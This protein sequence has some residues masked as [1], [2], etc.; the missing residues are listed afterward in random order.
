MPIGRD[1]R[2][3]FDELSYLERSIGRTGLLALKPVLSRN[4]RDLWEL[5]VLEQASGGERSLR[6]GG[7]KTAV[8]P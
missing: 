5:Y 2:A 6:R 7:D 4:S 1:V 8:E 3:A